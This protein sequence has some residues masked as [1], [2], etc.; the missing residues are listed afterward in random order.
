[1]LVASGWELE[2]SDTAPRPCAKIENVS[3]AARFGTKALPSG[4][5]GD[6]V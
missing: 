6:S 1:M 5:N 4:T 2:A 3:P